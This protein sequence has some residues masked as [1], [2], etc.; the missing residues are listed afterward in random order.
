MLVVIEASVG[1]A[2]VEWILDLPSKE[3]D[4]SGLCLS[5]KVTKLIG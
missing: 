4:H 5:F 1:A 2:L 3:T